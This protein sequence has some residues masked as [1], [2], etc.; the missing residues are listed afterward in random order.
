MRL[1]QYRQQD[2][3]KLPRAIALTCSAI[4]L[5]LCANELP[6]LAEKQPENSRRIF[7]DWCRQKD[8]LSPETKHTVEVLLEKAETTECGAADRKLSILTQLDLSTVNCQ[9][10]TVIHL[11]FKNQQNFAATKPAQT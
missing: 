9:L 2:V 5:A 6:V 10:S 7:A 8:D 4:G 3:V 11:R 1:K